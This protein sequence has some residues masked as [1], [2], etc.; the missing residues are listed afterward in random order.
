M[1]LPVTAPKFEDYFNKVEANRLV[2]IMGKAFSPEPNGNYYHWDKLR[3][4]TPPDGFSCEEWWLGIT[5]SRANISKQLPFN[6]K[7]GK[8][9]KYVPTEG[10]YR[11]LHLIDQRAGGS[12]AAPESDLLNPDTRDRYLINSLFEEAIT[13]SQLEGAA[14]TRKVAKDMLR[15]QRKPS[16]KSE[17]MIVNNYRAMLFIRDIRNDRLTPELIRE[18]HKIVCDGTL[19]DKNSLGEW[20]SDSDNIQV[21]DNRDGTTL[22]IPPKAEELQERIVNLCNFA[23]EK[24]T[25]QVFLHPVVKAI[26]LH[27]MIGYD[28]PF[29]DGNG[30]T[31]RTLFYWYMARYGYWLIEY[32]SISSVLKHAPA[33]YARSY[34][35]TE[36]DNSDVTYFLL[37]QCEVIIKAIDEL[38]AYVKRKANEQKNVDKY[39][40]QAGKK[41]LNHRQTALISHAIRHPDTMFTILSHQTSHGIT[42][43]TART[44]LLSLV[45]MELLTMV[46]RGKKFEFYVPDDLEARLS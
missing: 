22:H 42:Y 21:Q 20:R 32:I 14:T 11:S 8:A 46:K 27:F 4:L 35:Y 12:I 34:L 37:H 2:E 45:E 16:N 1:K 24:D 38:N 9:F 7:N 28:H 41:L 25:G 17:R 36:T 23:N 18:L 5:M 26:L 6:D 29:V 15:R 40:K 39:L 13:S 30:R 19:D 31:A 3:H 44:D 10:L 43:Q 33:K